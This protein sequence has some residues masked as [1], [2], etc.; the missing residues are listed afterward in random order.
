MPG[1]RNDHGNNPEAAFLPRTDESLAGLA[2]FGRPDT[3]LVVPGRPN[4]I[5]FNVA[6]PI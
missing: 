1:C 4:A 5:L 2:G 3:A 6:S